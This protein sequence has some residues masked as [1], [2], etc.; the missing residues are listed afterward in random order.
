MVT[1]LIACL[2]F[3]QEEQKSPELLLRFVEEAASTLGETLDANDSLT[4][5]SS[6]FG[7]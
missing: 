2:F 4:L 1:T 5:N 7:K 6:N 3:I